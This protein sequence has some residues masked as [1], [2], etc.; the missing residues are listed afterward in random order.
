[1]EALAQT[2]SEMV[3]ALT[4]PARQAI[5]RRTTLVRRVPAWRYLVETVA[6]AAQMAP[7]RASHATQAITRLE[8]AARSVVSHAIR[9]S[10]KAQLALQMQTV[11]AHLALSC[12]SLAEPVWSA[13]QLEIV[14]AS[15][16]MLASSTTARCASHARLCRWKEEAA[17]R[18][19]PMGPARL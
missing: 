10:M 11:C 8:I 13:L 16:A 18:A 15:R 14:R 6:L 12:L 7:A 9:V 5:S 1:M 19:T 3:H 2:A 4:L 17:A